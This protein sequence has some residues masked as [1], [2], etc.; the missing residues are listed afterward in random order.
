MEL[1]VF[2]LLIL[3]STP[4]LFAFNFLIEG[5]D[6]LRPPPVI[7]VRETNFTLDRVAFNF[8]G[9]SFSNALYNPTF[10]SNSRNR[11]Q[12]LNKFEGYGIPV[13]RRWGEWN[14]DLG[15]IDTCDSCTVYN[16]DES[17]RPIYLNRLK[18]S[19]VK[20]WNKFEIEFIN[21]NNYENPFTDVELLAEFISPDGR[22][23]ET[24]G[25]YD[26]NGVWKLRFMPDQT[27]EWEYIIWFSDQSRQKIYGKFQCIP[28]DIPGMIS[29]DEK[30]PIW[31]GFKGGHH[32]FLRSF[33]VGDR[34]FASNWPLEKRNEFLDWVEGKYNTLSIASHYLNRNAKGRGQGWKTPNLWNS[35]EQRPNPDEYSKM[36]SILDDLAERKI[37]IFPF[38]G[39]FGQS[40]NYPHNTDNQ[41][42]YIKYTLARLGA[43]WNIL[44][45]VS[46]PEPLLRRVNEF[47]KG[48]IDLWGQL[49][50]SLNTYN[51]LLTVHNQPDQNPFVN[52]TWTSYQCIQGPKTTN[53]DNLYWRII[54]NRNMSQPLYA[55]ET[56]WYGNLY[57]HEIIGR[58]Y[59]DDE[60]RRN[61]WTIVMAGGTINFADNNGDS[62]SG[63]S[64]TLNFKEMHQEKHEIIWKVWNFFESIPFYKLSPSPNVVNNGFCLAKH[65]EAYLIYLPFGGE[66]SV[67]TMQNIYQAEWVKGA[68]TNIRI[69]VGLYNGEKIAAPSQDDW[70]LY[71]KRK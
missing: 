37:I 23:V 57:H 30:N 18:K 41:H 24:W 44:L 40:A 14:N 19:E 17:L 38:G 67:N 48:Q 33:H 60:L 45:N 32:A 4:K 55:Q 68:E 34:F 63:F 10:N 56:L 47:T 11:F 21:N 6:Q 46:G 9:I 64:G 27:G 70:L 54:R 49:I 12:W 20:R 8:T 1:K 28:S 59:S 58:E 43:Y 25:F 65:G 5:P 26:N 36:E 62:S 61:A 3:L 16:R 31:F 50:S 69:P 42:L 22:K 15:F 29:A 2:L 51:H 13:I 39:F 7:A 66:I 53:L 52:S 35:K 71:L